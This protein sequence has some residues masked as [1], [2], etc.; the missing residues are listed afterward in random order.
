MTF[1]HEGIANWSVGTPS[2]AVASKV[3]VVVRRTMV[4]QSL[5]QWLYDIPAVAALRESD[6]VFPIVET[7]HV[8]GICLMVGTIATVDLRLTG[9]ILRAQPVT[10][11]STS[12]LPYTWA[13]FGLMLLTGLPLFAA[14]SLQL[15]G[16][17]AFR[18]KLVLLL[19]AGGNALLFH[20]TAYGGVSAWDRAR[21]IPARVKLFAY[22]SLSLWFAVVVSGR[23]IAVFRAH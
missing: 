7:L 9:H 14:E 23:L 11:I 6:D 10:V 15:Y 5:C 8:L 1:V 16:N 17:P 21:E 3:Y 19:L 4:L 2:G 22:T 12:L 13:G 18:I 20:N